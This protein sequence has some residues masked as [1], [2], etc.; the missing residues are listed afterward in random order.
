MLD[1]FVKSFECKDGLIEAF[2]SI[3]KDEKMDIVRQSMGDLRVWHRIFDER[4]SYLHRNVFLTAAGM[5]S[6]VETVNFHY[7]YGWI[8]QAGSIKAYLGK[9][10]FFGGISFEIGRRTYFSGHQCPARQ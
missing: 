8:I 10:S 6:K 9:S 7:K 2:G 5:K 1:T 4:A 3:S